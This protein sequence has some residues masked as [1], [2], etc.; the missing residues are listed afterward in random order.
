MNR[1]TRRKLKSKKRGKTVFSGKR[2]G[3]RT[4]Q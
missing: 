1:A 3:Y 4:G 2:L